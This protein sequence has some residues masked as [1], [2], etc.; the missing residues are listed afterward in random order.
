LL[1]GLYDRSYRDCIPLNVALEITLRCNLRCVHCYNFD[2]NHPPPPSVPEL[3]FGEIVALLDDLRESGTLFLSFTGGEPMSH[4]RFWDL[5]DAAAARRFAVILLTNGTL[6]TEEACGRLAEYRNLLRVSLSLYGATPRTHEDVTRTVG[7]FR[8]ATDGLRRLKER[9]VPVTLKF[10]ILRS[11]ASEVEAMTA[12]AASESLPCVL[13]ASITPCYDGTAGSLRS[14]VDAG[15]IE[16]LYRGPLRPLLEKGDP[17]PPDDGFTCNCARGNAAVSSTGD[18]WPCIAAPLRAGNVRERSFRE[19]WTGSEVFRHIR[20][21]RLADFKAC[22][23]CPL[24]AWCL[25][26]PGM[27]LLHQGDYTG[28]DPWTCREAEIIR[29]ILG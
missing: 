2:R 20:G 15:T 4:P 23:P 27:P 12:W 10:V 14:R 11:N 25:R 1:E 19:I 21:L 3:A 22:A 17:A 26:T 13:D 5:M 24:K 7:S 6:L 29:G 18:V 16:A 28:A 9:R 8:R